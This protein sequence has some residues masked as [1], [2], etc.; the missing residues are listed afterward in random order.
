MHQFRTMGVCVALL[1]ETMMRIVCELILFFW[2]L[3]LKYFNSS[4]PIILLSSNS[5][6]ISIDLIWTDIFGDGAKPELAKSMKCSDSEV[7]CTWKE[8][9]QLIPT[10]IW[11][12]LWNFWRNQSEYYQLKY[13]WNMKWNVCISS[14]NARKTLTR[15]GN[16]LV[17]PFMVQDIIKSDELLWVTVNS[18]WSFCREIWENFSLESNWLKL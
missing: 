8:L 4:V 18:V 10:Q 14:W 1:K 6:W 7:K 5:T 15:N 13:T 17:V 12:Y 16:C 2:T 9:K 11:H 3:C